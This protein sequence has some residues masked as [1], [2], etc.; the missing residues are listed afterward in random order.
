[1]PKVKVDLKELDTLAESC[2]FPISIKP[3]GCFFVLRFTCCLNCLTRLRWFVLVHSCSPLWRWRARKGAA[4]SRPRSSGYEPC[5]LMLLQLAA[6]TVSL[7][8]S[9]AWTRRWCNRG[10]CVARAAQRARL[11]QRVEM[12]DSGKR[13]EGGYLMQAII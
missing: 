6:L 12:R 4:L 1:M 7:V 3:V 2:T 9:N 13:S 5:L 8:R 10:G 11:A